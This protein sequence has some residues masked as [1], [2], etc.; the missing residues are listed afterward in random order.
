MF[1][2][3]GFKG[4]VLAAAC[5]F[6]AGVAAAEE[7]VVSFLS[8]SGARQ[9]RAFSLD[10]LKAFEQFEFVTTNNFV[11]GPVSFRGPRVRDVL[12]EAGA[13]LRGAALLTA[14]NDYSVQ[15]DLAEFSDYGVIFALEADGKAL[16][17]RDKGP[18]WLMYPIDDHETLQVPATNSRLIWQLV[19]LDVE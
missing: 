7:L 13:P 15:V 11:D 10:E 8:E 2:V 9:E 18:I 17:R 16:S 3:T 14:A 12:E 6:L 4:A 19:R 1:F 5:V